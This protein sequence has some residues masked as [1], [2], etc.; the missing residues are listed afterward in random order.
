[1]QPPT[2]KQ[3]EAL[4]EVAKRDGRRADVTMLEAELKAASPAPPPSL[5]APS[6]RHDGK[7]EKRFVEPR[8][9]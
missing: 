3:L 6:A 4:L 2:R 7:V 8:A 1:M 9:A 5:T